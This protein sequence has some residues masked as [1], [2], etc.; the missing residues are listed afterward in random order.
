MS[1]AIYTAHFGDFPVRFVCKE[2]TVYVSR[3]DFLA[4]MRDCYV[5]TIRE[6]A[7]RFIDDGIGVF[8]VGTDKTAAVI[9]KDTIGQVIHFNAIGNLLDSIRCLCFMP[10]NALTSS[11][12]R[13][14]AFRINALYKWYI[15]TMPKV[16]DFFGIT[17][18]DMLHSVAQRLDVMNPPLI[19]NVTL[20]NGFYTAVC[21]ALHLVTEAQTIDELRDRVWE[22]A[23]ELVELNNLPIDADSMRLH[24]DMAPPAHLQQVM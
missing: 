8:G 9:N 12:L 11:G 20:S 19:V 18:D 14:T 6:F 10:D 17:V 24:F 13:E 1:Q 5:A 16:D 21:D 15:F 4:A 23:P 7:E 2:G 22:L 3:D